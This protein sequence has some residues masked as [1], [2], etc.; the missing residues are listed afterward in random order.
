MDNKLIPLQNNFH[1]RMQ[2]W[3]D[4][5]VEKGTKYDFDMR[6]AKCNIH[7]IL[8]FYNYYYEDDQDVLGSDHFYSNLLQHA[9]KNDPDA[10]DDS[11]AL[12]VASFVEQ[13][14]IK[15][16]KLENDDEGWTTV[17]QEKKEDNMKDL[18]DNINVLIPPNTYRFHANNLFKNIIDYCID[19][20]LTYGNFNTSNS[21]TE[22]EDPEELI[23][24]RDMKNSFYELLYKN[25]LK[26]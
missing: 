9:R 5:K 23:F 10:I 8:D 7:H 18:P 16:K 13:R 21:M 6:Y 22:E 1:Y 15:P 2:Q 20:E 26:K 11:E 4:S 25:Y 17:G 12:F 19:N 14:Y 24:N 3:L